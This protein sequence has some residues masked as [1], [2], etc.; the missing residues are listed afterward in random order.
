MLL[1]GSWDLC[2][3]KLQQSSKLSVIICLAQ[4]HS[5]AKILSKIYLINE[6]VTSFFI[7]YLVQ[8][9]FEIFS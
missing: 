7:Q 6:F 3:H 4:A 9:D 8:Q 2:N 5:V 1:N